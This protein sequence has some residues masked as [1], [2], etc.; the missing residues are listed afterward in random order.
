MW[1]K[2]IQQMGQE[3]QIEQFQINGEYGIDYFHIFFNYLNLKP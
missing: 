1:Q 3:N 2:S